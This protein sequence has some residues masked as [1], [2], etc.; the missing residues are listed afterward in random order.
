MVVERTG[1]Y[2][3]SRHHIS[4]YGTRYF[5]DAVKRDER[6]EFVDPCGSWGSEAAARAFI[7]KEFS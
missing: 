1:A 7:A 4:G 3:L 6:G 2:E 5:V